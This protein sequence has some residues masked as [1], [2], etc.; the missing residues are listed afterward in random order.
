MKMK[1]I[2]LIIMIAIGCRVN[3]LQE[4]IIYTAHVREG[5]DLEKAIE[6]SFVDFFQWRMKNNEN[7]KEQGKKCVILHKNKE[8][9]YFGYPFGFDSNEYIKVLYKTKLNELEE[10]FPSYADVEGYHI[11]QK[12]YEYVIKGK[13]PKNYSTLD[14]RIDYSVKLVNNAIEVLLKYKA[15]KDILINKKFEYIVSLDKNT[16]EL[17]GVIEL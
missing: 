5:K 13:E 4:S 14:Y 11:K 7:E 6:R 2:G 1:L 8:F 15:R 17:L 9:I 16:L 12:A 3:Y 10:K